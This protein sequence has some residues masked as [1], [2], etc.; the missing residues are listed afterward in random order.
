[1]NSVRNF[2]TPERVKIDLP[3]FLILGMVA[4]CGIMYEYL[5]SHYAARVLG[6]TET[7]IFTIIS[8][9]LASM[10]I[11][12]W[13]AGLFKKRL[14]DHFAILESL[15]ALTGTLGIM[16]IAASYGLGHALP[17]ILSDLYGMDGNLLIQGGFIEKLQTI[18]EWTPYF[19]AAI[20]GTLVGIE[21]PLMGRIRE[22]EYGR[23]IENNMGSMY[24]VD[25]VFAA[26]GAAAWIAIMIKFPVSLSTSII[27]SI[28]VF[29][30]ITFILVFRKRLQ[31]V[32]RVVA[33]QVIAV[34]SVVC[35]FH[36]GEDV[37][38]WSESLL[39]KDT[40]ILTQNTKFQHVALTKKEK[41]DLSAE[42][43][44][45]FINGHTQFNSWDEKIYHSYLVTPAMIITENPKRVLVVGGGDGLAVRNVLDWNP[46]K[47]VLMD[48]DGEVLD[49]FT[50]PLIKDNKVINASLLEL[51]EYSFSDARVEKRV[52]DANLSIDKAIINKEKYDVII[53]D[54]PDPNHPDL[55]RLYSTSFYAKLN[56]VL[57]KDG[58]LV[59]QS[60][61][62]YRSRMA[63]MSI[64]KTVEAS[65]FSNVEQYHTNVPSFGEWG[66]TIATK[67]GESPYRRL[68]KN[69]DTYPD[70]G[71]TNRFMILGSFHFPKK[72]YKGYDDVKINRSNGYTIYEYNREAWT[73]LNHAYRPDS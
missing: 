52:G 29:S 41:T 35:V 22:M 67:S 39:Y 70:D 13:L 31:R 50:T 64:K 5:I 27:A 2:F 60:T 49:L 23:R 45:F 56:H 65:G 53:V 1:M 33:L 12:A 44:S 32:K 71:H 34:M 4:S 40:V 15:I 21:I 57:D 9:M 51:N 66:W 3:T 61:S 48:L 11:G 73:D 36:Y 63:F 18:V 25:Y 43:L 68:M 37:E 20:L 19:M 47:V 28:N 16:L 17:G 46:E 58:A 26:I 72:F 30:G 6:S 54:L 62:P 14:Y 69:N 55:N 10:G 8:I 24:G 38:V 42:S 59:I 7:V